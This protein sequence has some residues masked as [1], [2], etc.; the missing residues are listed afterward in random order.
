M[1]PIRTAAT[2]LLLLTGAI[3]PALADSHEATAPHDAHGE[4]GTAV[5]AEAAA[6]AHATMSQAMAID[7]TGDPDIDFARAMIPHHQGAIDMAQVVLEHGADPDLR[8]LAQDVI[9]AQEAEIAFLRDWLARN[10][11]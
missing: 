8:K 2:A 1:P 7:P 11:K 4:M 5:A 3:A 10:D 6:A 9:E